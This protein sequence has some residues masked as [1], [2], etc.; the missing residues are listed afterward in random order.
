MFPKMLAH[1]STRGIKRTP[2]GAINSTCNT[3]Y[4][5]IM[6]RYPTSCAIHIFCRLLPRHGHVLYHLN[7]RFMQFCKI[8][9]FSRPVIHFSINV[10]GVLAVP[11]WIDPVSYTHLTL[12][13]SDL[14]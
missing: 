2:V 1:P 14:V 12:P 10:N 7:K 11:W 3:P 5:R 8:C 6:M 4:I 9:F 13:T